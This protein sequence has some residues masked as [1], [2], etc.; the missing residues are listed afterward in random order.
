M[1]V[2]TRHLKDIARAVVVVLVCVAG[3]FALSR[4][5]M[6]QADIH[7]ACTSTSAKGTL[8]FTTSYRVA[9]GTLG[10]VCVGKADPRLEEL[11]RKLTLVVPQ[12]QLRH[13]SEF[14]AYE[15]TQPDVRSAAAF[16]Q[17]TSIQPE[18]FR[19][20]FNQQSELDEFFQWAVVVHE[21]GHVLTGRNKQKMYMGRYKKRCPT[22]TD[23]NSCYRQESL[24]NQWVEQFW[25]REQ[26]ASLK[27]RDVPYARNQR[28]AADAS[29]ISRYAAT[30][31]EEDFAE[32][33]SAMVLGHKAANPQQQLKL[34]WLA[35]QP[36]LREFRDVAQM[37]SVPQQQVSYAECGT[38]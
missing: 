7:K 17:R 36:V 32:S 6:G 11:W 13:L 33:F 18:G 15:A 35:K 9:N 12:H 2:Q 5:S 26:L 19:I 37:N 3:M 16:T 24:L 1:R 31:P 29:F 27:A 4:T 8:S 20:S 25:T 22:Y 14:S 38:G 30:S 28:C 21:F 10:E 23:G 34:D